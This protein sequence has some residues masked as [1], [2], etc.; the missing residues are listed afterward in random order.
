MNRSFLFSLK[1]GSSRQVL[2]VETIVFCFCASFP[3]A[4]HHFLRPFMALFSLWSQTRAF[5]RLQN[6]RLPINLQ[7]RL[8][9]SIAKVTKTTRFVRKRT[10]YVSK[11]TAGRKEKRKKPLKQARINGFTHWHNDWIVLINRNTTMKT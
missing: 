1:P 7:N 11:R 9:N 3:A 8:T 4:S 5:Y 6:A 10:S 2:P